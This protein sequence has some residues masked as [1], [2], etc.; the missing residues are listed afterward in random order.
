LAPS[1]ARASKREGIWKRPAHPNQDVGGNN[2][3]RE[4]HDRYTKALMDPSGDSSE[5]GKQKAPFL[6]SSQLNRPLP[7]KMTALPTPVET[8]YWSERLNQPFSKPV[9]R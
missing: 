3:Q 1:K 5:H 7:S 4:A 8:L 6:L 9:T 2:E